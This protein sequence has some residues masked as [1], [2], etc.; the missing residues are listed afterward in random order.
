MKA[1]HNTAL[2]MYT[3]AFLIHG[4]AHRSFR[5]SVALKIQKLHLYM[6]INENPKNEGP[7]LFKIILLR[8]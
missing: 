3:L 8:L 2:Q 6:Y 7:V 5:F 4:L 1:D